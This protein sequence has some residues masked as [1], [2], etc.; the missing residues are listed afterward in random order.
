MKEKSCEQKILRASYF[1]K[2]IYTSGTVVETHLTRAPKIPPPFVSL[3]FSPLHSLVYFP[4][5][6]LTHSSLS[7]SILYI[8]PSLSLSASSFFLSV[9]PFPLASPSPLFHPFH[10]DSAV[11]KIFVDASPIHAEFHEYSW[12]NKCCE[13]KRWRFGPATLSLH[14][15]CTSFH[16]AQMN[17]TRL[18]SPPPF[19]S[20]HVC[21]FNFISISVIFDGCSPRYT[22]R[23]AIVK[24]RVV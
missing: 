5:T 23:L 7:H 22:Y 15:R 11:G 8:H 20:I 2:Y 6:I 17:V 16:F 13:F 14:P 24:L 9:S 1:L 10:D 4:S 21:S 3:S 18:H 12:S 19:T